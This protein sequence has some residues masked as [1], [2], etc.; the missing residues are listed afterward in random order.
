VVDLATGDGSLSAENLQQMVEQRTGVMIGQTTIRN[1]LHGAQ[2]FWRRHKK[3][4]NL[5]KAQMRARQQFVLDWNGPLFNEVRNKNL[6]FTDESRFCRKPDGHWVWRRRGVYRMHI[7]AP[8][9]K[10]PPVSIMVWGAIGIGY[11]SK[12]QVVVGS[13]TG[14]TH[15]KI[16]R[17]FFTHCNAANRPFQWVLVQDG[18]SPHTAD[19]TINN[20]CDD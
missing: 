10:Y 13:I 9:D 7:M 16:L 2:F 4:P 5:T 20:I 17:K 14:E 3:C 8:T 15:L 12:L 1:I 19:V 11:K 6:I 18:A